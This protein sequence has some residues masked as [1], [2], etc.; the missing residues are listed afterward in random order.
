[1]TTY[2]INLLLVA[3]WPR[4]RVSASPLGRALLVAALL[5]SAYVLVRYWH[6]LRARPARVRHTL[7]S[8]RA[9]TLVLAACAL[10]GVSV[11]YES[12][13]RA[14]VLVRSARGGVAGAES[15]AAAGDHQ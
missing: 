5:V 15:D 3:A 8:L 9:V 14:R 7:L 10:G 6:S 12:E 2:S 13:S 11:E 1:M 4:L